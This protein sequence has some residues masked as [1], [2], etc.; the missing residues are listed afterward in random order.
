MAI[1]LPSMVHGDGITKRTQVHF[2]GYNHN[3]HAGGGQIYDMQNLTSD[4]CPLLASRGVRKRVVYNNVGNGGVY[5]RDGEV[6]VVDGS[7]FH[8]LIMEDATENSFSTKNT[9]DD[10]LDP[11]TEKQIVSIGAYIIIMPDKKYYNV[12]DNSYGSLEATWPEEDATTKTATIT[13]G[14]YAGEEAKANTI[15]ADGA[16]WEN[17]FKVGDA[18]EISGCK[19]HPANN[20]TIIIREIDGN[21]LRFYENSF[22]IDQDGDKEKE[23]TIKRTVP[24]MDFLC[25]N[26]NRLWGCKGNTIYAS[27]LGDP[28]NWNVFD[29]IS[30]DSFTTDVNAAGSYFT[31]GVG[32]AGG[33]TGCISYLG[34]PCF[35]K[36]DHIYKIYGD[37]PANFQVMG[38]ASLGVSA[39]SGKSLAIA[40]ETLFY[41]SRAGITAYTGGIPQSVADAFGN[42]KY[43]NAVAGSDGVKYYVSMEDEDGKYHL[44]VYDTRRN[45]W[46]KED[47]TKI[48]CFSGEGETLLWM[49]AE[50]G[51]FCIGKIQEGWNVYET[52]QV[53]SFAE[54]GDFTDGDP[55][56]KGTGKLQLRLELS[57]GASVTV[58]LQFDSDGAWQEVKTL[59]AERKRSFYLPIIPR[60]A[61]HFR[62]RVEGTGQWWLHSMVRESYSGSEL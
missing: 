34:Y 17:Y 28:F 11:Q 29:G 49:P 18:V 55:N 21:S 45:L 53:E 32:S 43:K 33:F 47:N 57:E 3:K 40:G 12:T 5:M 6:Y 7:S 20:K 14:Y 62:V 54:F 30:T 8:K 48:S 37:R 27:K 46:H 52:E 4:Y 35:F 58:K 15:S 61:D 22:T 38:S 41:L 51:I 10:F 31:T 25:E 60:R 1:G 13:D 50:G 59:D 9:V 44:F 42:T 19:E 39:G 23:I 56:K 16:M 36:E 24:D 26:E 2:G